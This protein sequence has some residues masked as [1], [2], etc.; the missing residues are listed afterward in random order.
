[1]LGP[2]WPTHAL[3]ERQPGQGEWLLSKSCLLNIEMGDFHLQIQFVIP[4]ITNV[5]VNI[6]RCPDL[7]CLSYCMGL[8]MNLVWVVVGWLWGGCG[9]VVVG[10]LC[11]LFLWRNGNTFAIKFFF[12]HRSCIS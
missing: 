9:V 6:Q 2:D 11:A 7:G 12:N 3:V 1:M 4:K 8:G 5:L 10:W